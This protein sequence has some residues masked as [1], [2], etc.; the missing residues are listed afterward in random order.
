MKREHRKLTDRELRRITTPR[1]VVKRVAELKEATADNTLRT[2]YP[3][4]E[5][6]V[7]ECTGAGSQREETLGGTE[8]RSGK[9]DR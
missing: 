4:E 7:A 3:G 1:P 8:E 9:Y 5:P 6:K 2:D